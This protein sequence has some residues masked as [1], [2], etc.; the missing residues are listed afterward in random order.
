[1]TRDD[2]E[3]QKAWQNARNQQPPFLLFVVVAAV[4]GVILILRWSVAA[5]SCRPSREGTG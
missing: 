1:M 3:L 4:A 5:F 2:V